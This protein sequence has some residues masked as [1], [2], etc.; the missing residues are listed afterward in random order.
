VSP[1]VSVV[2]VHYEDP[3]RLAL[4]LAGLAAQ[5]L[6]SDR[7][8]V[9]VADDGSRVLPRLPALP[10]ATRVVRQPDL[11]FRAAAAR[12]LGVR[13]TTAPLVSF[14]D[15]DTV[16]EPGYLRAVLDA[17]QRVG[18]R[19]E[20]A[21]LVG[22]RRHADLAGWDPQR[23]T[24]WLVDGGPG[25][26]ELP[27]PG[28]LKDG[29]RWTDD[30][31]AADDESYRY[32]ISAVLTVHRRLLE[33]AGGFDERF[34]GYG[35]E[36]WELANRC[37]LAGGRFRHVRDAVAWHDGPDFAGRE[38]DQRAVQ[39]AQA[40]ALARLLPSA[41]TR[42][43]GPVWEYPQVLVEVD[44]RGWT[45]EQLLLCVAALLDGSD[46]GVWLRDGTHVGALGGDPRVRVG[47]VSPDVERRARYR[48][49][50]G[51]PVEPAEPLAD[52]VRRAPVRVGALSVRHAR[53]RDVADGST[54][55]TEVDLRHLEPAP[56]LGG[57][58]RSRAESAAR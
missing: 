18:G 21:L 27:E 22:R 13:A 19:E 43:R 12:N 42:P 40:L 10:F 6:R 32:V 15:G 41:A 35:G 55:A 56:S 33:R 5:T 53:D 8:E 58:L 34:T 3:D 52:L 11:G 31:A 16:P 14:L 9:V 47:P 2:V 26:E 54:R 7:F 1:D 46:A 36:D 20:D 17:A 44:D 29:Y 48:V 28:W 50:L 25:P 4:V 37:W 30:L 39:N 45:A 38:V 51:L 57:L 24:A 23:L 49:R